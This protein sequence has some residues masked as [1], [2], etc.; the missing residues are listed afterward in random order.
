MAIDA[1]ELLPPVLAQLLRQREHREEVGL[2]ESGGQDAVLP[3]LVDDGAH[4]QLR[5]C[6]L[7]CGGG[8]SARDARALA[9]RRLA[10]GLRLAMPHRRR[11]QRDRVLRQRQ[12]LHRQAAGDKLRSASRLHGE[13]MRGEARAQ[14]E[15]P[16]K[17]YTLPCS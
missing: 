3:A 5:L 6:P 4:L 7:G 1:S 10:L 12:L 17:L 15:R 2:A 16:D 9:Q 11:A 8:A 14:G 13:I